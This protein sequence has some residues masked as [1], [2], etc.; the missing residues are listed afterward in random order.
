[1][2]MKTKR[3][4]QWLIA[5]A[6]A[7]TSLSVTSCKDQPDEY[8]IQDGTPTIYYIR[9][10][11]VS[12]KDSLMTE[13]SM[14]TT[15]CII[16]DNLRSIVDLKFNDQAAVLNTS[17]MTD[18]ALIVTVPKNIPETVTDKIYFTNNSNETVTYDFHVVIPA[19]V[20][21]SMSNEWAKAGEEVKIIGDYF[22]DYENSPLTV[23]FGEDYT[24]DRSNISSITRNFITF[25]MPA[26]APHEQIS[27]TSI[28]GSTK[29]S[30]KYMDDRG[31]LFDFDTPCNTGV[32]LGNHGWH[33]RT[34]QSD[35]TSLSGNY[36]I[37]GDAAMGSDGGWNDGNFSFEY[38]PGNWRNPETYEDYPRM[39]DIADFSK[40]EDLNLKF[41]MCIEEGRDWSAAPMQIFF[42]SASL[43]SNGNAGATDIYGATLGGANNTYFH[44]QG[45]LSRGLYMPWKDT[46][47]KLY[48]TGG[49]WVTVTM[50]LSEFVWDW[51]GSKMS[52]STYLSANDFA[53]FSI[54]I[55]KGGYNDKS[56]LPEGVDCNPLIKIDNI[57][58]VPNK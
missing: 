53:A 41:E 4:F 54:F 11:A 9:P 25:T 35:D 1:M 51:D 24:L 8:E 50:P 57:R 30:F 28:F 52:S 18:N 32:V 33:A 39:C 46:D 29:G 15:I 17:Y 47:D 40:P 27:V 7:V 3:Y 26:D 6:V 43:I 48:N 44:E 5:A 45:T 56:A 13:A 22:L 12:A 49:K 37:M 23:K 2:I 10:V 19:P 55:V 21:S 58:V 14:G 16:G 36:L 31:M 34:I 42:G 38:W 20:V